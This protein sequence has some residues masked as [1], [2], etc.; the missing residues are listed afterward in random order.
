MKHFSKPIYFY[1]NVKLKPGGSKRLLGPRIYRE[2][3][4]GVEKRSHTRHDDICSPFHIFMVA[5]NSECK[6]VF[7]GLVFTGGQQ[8]QK[9]L[10]KVP[11]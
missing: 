6:E 3:I 8:A 11:V 9:V 1:L 5:R 2:D 4:W 10:V 7:L